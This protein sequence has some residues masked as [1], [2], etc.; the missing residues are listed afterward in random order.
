MRLICLIK[1]RIKNACAQIRMF[2]VKNPALHLVNQA[3]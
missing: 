2:R 1:G 3:I